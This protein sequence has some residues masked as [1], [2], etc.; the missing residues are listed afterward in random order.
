MKKSLYSIVVLLVLFGTLFLLATDGWVLGAAVIYLVPAALLLLAVMLRGFFKGAEHLKVILATALWLL[1]IAVGYAFLADFISSIQTPLLLV[2]ITGM[3]LVAW[4]LLVRWIARNTKRWMFVPVVV[5]WPIIILASVIVGLSSL[6]LLRTLA[7]DR[8]YTP[9]LQTPL[10]APDQQVAAYKELVRWIPKRPWQSEQQLTEEEL[11]EKIIVPNGSALRAK[12]VSPAPEFNALQHIAEPVEKLMDYSDEYASLK[13]DS[14]PLDGIEWQEIDR[15]FEQIAPLYRSFEEFLIHNPMALSSL[16]PDTPLPD[17]LWM[18]RYIQMK[19]FKIESLL[20][21][22]DRVA[23]ADE[24]ERGWDAIYGQ[25]Q[26]SCQLV[27][28]MLLVAQA[29]YLNIHYLERWYDEIPVSELSDMPAKL[30]QVDTLLQAALQKALEYELSFI[31]DY[32]QS[33]LSGDRKLTDFWLYQNKPDNF[34]ER[35]D[36]ELTEL[37][38]DPQSIRVKRGD[39]FLKQVEILGQPYYQVRDIHQKLDDLNY[40]YGFVESYNSATAMM[41]VLSRGRTHERT[42]VTRCEIRMQLIAHQWLLTGQLPENI[43][44]DPL[45][46]TPI[47]ATVKDGQLVLRT[48][49]QGE[50]PTAP[51]PI[52][53]ILE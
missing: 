33:V 14:E 3:T 15:L 2:S 52:V 44:V 49:W 9:L 41:G 26:G 17:Y 16:N 45:S 8:N 35:L 34:L 20:A 21:R 29:G 43:P 50:I 36:Q 18:R 51:D 23:A 31:D 12:I 11:D 30:D 47:D 53:Y 37:L 19:G 42:A 32:S 1:L 48:A 4:Y 39:D 27:H 7:I 28:V 10:S 6:V 25:L 5:I 22:G 46:G 40:D 38:F 24:Y 13:Q